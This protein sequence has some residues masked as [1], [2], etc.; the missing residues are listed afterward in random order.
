MKRYLKISVILFP[1]N[2][3]L[4]G[5]SSSLN[6]IGIDSDKPVKLKNYSIHS[7]IGDDWEYQSNEEL[8]SVMFYRQSDD[9]IQYITGNSRNTFINVY[10]DSSTMPTKNV[11][12]E[13]FADG[14][15]NSEFQI[16]EPNLGRTLYGKP[17]LSTRDTFIIGEKTL[18][19]MIY[20]TGPLYPSE[21]HLYVYL[22]NHFEDTAVFYLF[23]IEEYGAETFMSSDYDFNQINNV[24][25]TFKCDED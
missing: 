6:T 16:M 1:I 25:A 12:R 14:F 17:I 13:E 8:Q 2:I 15:I 24:L 3:F 23:I 20:R 18:Y 19:R 7:P 21:G 22:P 4:T 10:R 5:C 9:I 11:D